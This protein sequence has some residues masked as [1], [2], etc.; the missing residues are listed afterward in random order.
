VDAEE[1]QQFRFRFDLVR[2][3]GP[4]DDWLRLVVQMHWERVPVRQ[5]MWMTVDR[6]FDDSLRQYHPHHSHCRYRWHWGWH[7]D[8]ESVAQ[9]VRWNREKAAEID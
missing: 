3:T 8:F 4:V 1:W 2:S 5:A 6:R 7:R 9:N